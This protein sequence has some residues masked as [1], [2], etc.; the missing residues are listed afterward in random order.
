LIRSQKKRKSLY[1]ITS[2]T[3]NNDKENNKE[4][5]LRNQIL[6]DESIFSE[7]NKGLVLLSK[8]NQSKYRILNNLDLIMEKTEPKIKN[9]DKVQAPFF[10][11]NINDLG[12]IE[13]KSLNN[14]QEDKNNELLNILNNYS[15]FTSEKKKSKIDQLKKKKDLILTE[16]LDNFKTNNISGKDVISVLNALNPFIIDLEIR[17]FDYIFNDNN[18]RYLEL[19]LTLLNQELDSKTN[20]EMVQAYLNRFLKVNFFYNYI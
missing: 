12:L 1:D 13:K 4:L 18:D 10:L 11:F 5:T 20:F 3:I 6:T 8:Q 15:H 9:K 17:N 7:Q 2:S 14:K 16:L 19:F